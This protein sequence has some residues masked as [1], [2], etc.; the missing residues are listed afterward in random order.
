MAGKGAVCNHAY[1]E[2]RKQITTPNEPL[3]D[4]R[5]MFAVHTMFRREFGLMSSLVRN[6]IADD[7]L[8]TTV[9]AD[10]VAFVSL[11]L[12]LHHEG[13][14]AHIWP[15]LYERGGEQIADIVHLMEQQHEAIFTRS[16]QVKDA[17]EVWHVNASA[18]ARDVLAEVLDQMVQSIKQHLEDEEQ[19]IVPLIE[20]YITEAEYSV[21][22]EEAGAH[23]PPEKLATV[24]GMMMYETPPAVVD[25]IVTHMPA[26]VRPVIRGVARK[27]YAA[28]AE[29]LYATSTPPRVTT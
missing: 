6:V 29:Q 28:Y 24:F 8:R 18:E 16:L 3:A 26:E 22:A 2:Q 9:V 7:K 14:D 10:H 20:R 21:L 1:M 5:D 27:A 25:K 4:V 17:L 23:T 15:L 12:H 11:M 19:R 13:E